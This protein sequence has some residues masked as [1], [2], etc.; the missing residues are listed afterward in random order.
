[1]KDNHTRKERK[2]RKD[3]DAENDISEDK[4]YDFQH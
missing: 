2:S 3:I 1:M 4:T